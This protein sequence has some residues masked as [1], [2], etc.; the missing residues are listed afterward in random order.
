MTDTGNTLT[1]I[2][3]RLATEEEVK[4]LPFREGSG[5]LIEPM[6]KLNADGEIIGTLWSLPDVLG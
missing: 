5:P 6:V 4:T 2:T 3:L 1:G